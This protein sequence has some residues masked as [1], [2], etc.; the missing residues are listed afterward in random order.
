MTAKPEL[1]SIAAE[2]APRRRVDLKALR[3]AGIDDDAVERNSR[4]L[5]SEWGASTSLA[6]PEEATPLASLRIVVP[7]YLDRAL[8]RDAAEQ[9]VTK[10]YLVMKA[11]QGAGYQIAEADL[12]EDKRKVKKRRM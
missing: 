7:D 1:P 9:R 6:S 12:V 3:P 11:L 8:A 2:L 5:G 4:A 10:Q